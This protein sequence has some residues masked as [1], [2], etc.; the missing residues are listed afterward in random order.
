MPSFNSYYNHHMAHPSPPLH[1]SDEGCSR[2]LLQ[3]HLGDQNEEDLEK[4]NRM[5]WR[6]FSLVYIGYISMHF[7]RNNMAC[8]K[9]G[10]ESSLGMSIDELGTL[11]T[12]Y[13]M[14]YAAGQFVS[15][16][17]GDTFGPRRVFVIGMA[18]SALCN[19]MISILTNPR[20]LFPFVWCLNGFFQSTGWANSIKVLGNWFPEDERSKA[21]GLWCTSSSVGSILATVLTGRVIATLPWNAAFAVP[22]FI[23]LSVAFAVCVML[24]NDPEEAGYLPLVDPETVP[25]LS[26]ESRKGIKYGNITPDTTPLMTASFKNGSFDMG[27]I[28]PP[29]SVSES[30]LRLML[31]TPAVWALGITYFGVK[32]IRYSLWFWL[33][34][35]LHNAQGFDTDN[36]AFAATAFDIGGVFGLLAAGFIADKLIPHRP[37]AA[38]VSLVGLATTLFILPTATGYSA[39]SCVGALWAVGFMLAGPDCIIAGAAAQEVGGKTASA[40][41]AGIINGLGSIGASFQGVI[42]SVI[43]SYGS[44]DSL[45]LFFGVVIIGSIVCVLPLAVDPHWASRSRRF[46]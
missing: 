8:A 35:Y 4:K 1:W 39:T 5:K 37:R 44:W 27:D 38:A 9:I 12:I 10:L 13:L 32:L 19:L 40:S 45:F 24:Y 18:G 41:A 36:A 20:T 28:D 16:A 22:S 6:A 15:G 7:T 31:R 23:L 26:S 46:S 42:V 11:D 14:S 2:V 33:P 17:L 29:A 30:P 21:I 25:L 34:L 43:V 3:G